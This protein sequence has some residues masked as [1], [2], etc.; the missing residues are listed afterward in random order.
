MSQT[1][2]FWNE[3][4]S[5]LLTLSPFLD[6][7]RRIRTNGRLGSTTCII[8]QWASSYNS[9][10]WLQIVLFI[11]GIQKNP[12]NV[13]P[14]TALLWNKKFH[15]QIFPHHERLRLSLHLKTVSDLWTPLFLAVLDRF[16]ARRGYPRCIFSDNSRN[17][18][19]AAKEIDANFETHLKDLQDGYSLNSCA[20]GPM[21]ENLDDLT[22]GHFLIHWKK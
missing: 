2:H 15:W 21:P 19:A 4:R 10:L 5:P 13:L 20:L 9:P 8:L 22:P 18:V 12:K 14:L 1:R 3:C 11:G 6:R 17:F 16:I 7:K